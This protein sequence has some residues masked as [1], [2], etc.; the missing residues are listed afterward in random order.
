MT[1]SPPP[2]PEPP[3]AT[4]RALGWAFSPLWDTD[5][6]NRQARAD[7]QLAYA[8]WDIEH[9]DAWRKYQKKLAKAEAKAQAEAQRQEQLRQQ[10]EAEAQASAPAPEPEPEDDLPWYLKGDRP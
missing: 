4:A 1:Y 3:S 7:H 9:G 5:R 10:A 2:P 8:E 6:I